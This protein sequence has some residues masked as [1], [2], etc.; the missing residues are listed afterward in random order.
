MEMT[1]LRKRRTVEIC[2][3]IGPLAQLPVALGDRRRTTT[4]VSLI[5][6]VLIVAACIGAATA[7]LVGAMQ[8]ASACWVRSGARD[9]VRGA[10]ALLRFVAANPA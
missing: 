5:V 4:M 3:L 9:I 1:P 6:T 8:L 2:A 7:A 10:E